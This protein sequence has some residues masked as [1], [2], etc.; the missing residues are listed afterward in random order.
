MR[1]IDI[2]DSEE[3]IRACI[4][5]IERAVP[6]CVIFDAFDEETHDSRRKGANYGS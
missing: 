6:V 3:L 1:Y 5:M 2:E 4:E